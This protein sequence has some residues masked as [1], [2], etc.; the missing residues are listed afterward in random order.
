MS[1]SRA[2]RC[3][4][5][6]SQQNQDFS[7][8]QR[9]C[10]RRKSFVDCGWRSKENFWQ[11]SVLGS[12]VQ[13][14]LWPDEGCESLQSSPRPVVISWSDEIKN[15]SQNFYLDV[16]S[17]ISE[18]TKKGDISLTTSW[19]GSWLTKRWWGWIK[20]LH[21]QMINW[22]LNHSQRKI[23]TCSQF[24]YRKSCISFD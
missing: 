10:R 23:Q 4:S 14:I 21:T 24:G 6:E 17:R 9:N 7:H 8:Q 1:T 2:M 12:R 22:K 3:R 16:A 19:W 11:L 13:K 20:V 15:K 5:Q 18:D